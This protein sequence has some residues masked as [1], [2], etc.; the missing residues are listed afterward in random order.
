MTSERALEIERAVI[1]RH[2]QDIQE[3]FKY[4]EDAEIAFKV[5]KYVGMIH[6]DLKKELD[7]EV[8]KGEIS[9]SEDKVYREKME[10]ATE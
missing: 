5:G 10:G 1:Y 8:R 3:V 6:A 7:K 9:E 2:I 4:T